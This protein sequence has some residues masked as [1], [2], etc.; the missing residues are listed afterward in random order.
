M[1]IPYPSLQTRHGEGVGVVEGADAEGVVVEDVGEGVS[2]M[3]ET[4]GWGILTGC[5]QWSTACLLR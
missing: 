4:S 1:T 2:G 5:R 3:E